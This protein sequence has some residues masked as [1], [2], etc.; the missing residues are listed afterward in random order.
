MSIRHFRPTGEFRAVR[1][2][3]SNLAEVESLIDTDY[4][5]SRTVLPDN[6]LY[7][8][9]G[10]IGSEIPLGDLVDSEGH[11]HQLNGVVV[12]PQF[13]EVTLGS[14]VAVNGSKLIAIEFPEV[15]ETVPHLTLSTDNARLT[16][17]YSGL[18]IDGFT[19]IVANWSSGTCPYSA[20]LR[21]R[22]EG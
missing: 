18:D 19:L 21:W 11:A 4:W 22:A 15:F 20:K 1:W 5:T 8:E 10:P 3:G 14:N 12:S 9:A 13:G 17:G 7:L 6:T 16:L 2:V